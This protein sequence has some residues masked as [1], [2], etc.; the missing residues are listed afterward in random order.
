VP[1]AGSIQTREDRANA[2]TRIAA[3]AKTVTP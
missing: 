2:I 1:I 3:A